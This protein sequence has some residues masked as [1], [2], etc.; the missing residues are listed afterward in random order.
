M[1]AMFMAA[2]AWAVECEQKPKEML[3]NCMANTAR[4]II[5]KIQCVKYLTHRVSIKP[6]C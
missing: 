6:V 4:Q 5:L 3:V 2:G 1:T